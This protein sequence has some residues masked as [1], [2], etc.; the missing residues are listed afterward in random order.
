MNIDKIEESLPSGSGFDY[1]YEFVE[2]ANGKL[3][4]KSFYHAMSERG[5]YV[6]PMPFKFTLYINCGGFDFKDIICNENRL[7]AYLGLK[8]YIGDT[9]WD[10]IKDLN[11]LRTIGEIIIND[12]TFVIQYDLFSFYAGVSG[13]TGIGNCY[14]VDYDNYLSLQDNF[15]AFV[16]YIKEDEGVSI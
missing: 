12:I 14:I 4:V 2:H 9:I 10:A 15:D 1:N 3:T 13:N 6:E 8:E 16:D 5:Y 11:V 7:I